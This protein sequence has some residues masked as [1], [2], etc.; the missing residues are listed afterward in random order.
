LGVE[1]E[2]YYTPQTTPPAR[3]MTTLRQLTL[4]AL[5]S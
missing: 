2:F 4:N 1:F 3:W 5:Q